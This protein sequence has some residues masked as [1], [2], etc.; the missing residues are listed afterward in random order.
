MTDLL[1]ITEIHVYIIPKTNRAAIFKKSPRAQEETAAFAIAAAHPPRKRSYF[2]HP[3]QKP[4]SPSTAG[5]THQRYG[6][7]KPS[8]A[9][10]RGGGGGPR[11]QGPRGGGG[12]DRSRGGKRH[13][14]AA[15]TA[16]SHFTLSSQKLR[17]DPWREPGSA[18]A[19]EGAAGG[20]AAGGSTCPAP[21]LPASAYRAA[22]PR[23]V[24]QK[25]KKKEKKN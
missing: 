6:R 24:K 11:R 5:H 3:P 19:E 20:M 12:A 9:G 15:A 21:Q 22:L 23:E 8:Q 13:H 10:V 14:A 16:R 18:R 7:F 25:K 2:K 4:H 1:K 17:G